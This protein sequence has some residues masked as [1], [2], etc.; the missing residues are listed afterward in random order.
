MVLP[1]EA[2]YQ[3]CREVPVTQ[4][5]LWQSTRVLSQ[6]LDQGATLPRFW[7]NHTGARSLRGRSSHVWSQEAAARMQPSLGARADAATPPCRPPGRRSHV[8]AGHTSRARCSLV[9]TGGTQR[10][11]GGEKGYRGFTS[12]S[13]TR[14]CIPTKEKDYP[15]SLSRPCPQTQ[16]SPLR[17]HEVSHQKKQDELFL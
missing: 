8:P 13:L 14:G 17:T 4:L 15:R 5:E 10:R 9:S 16:S 1:P 3:R 12:S 7:V 11:T 2:Q 6:P